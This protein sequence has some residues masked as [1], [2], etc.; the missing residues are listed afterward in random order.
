[1]PSDQTVPPM[2]ND[3]KERSVE[4]GVVAQRLRA[5]AVLTEDPGL[6]LRPTLQLTTMCES[7]LFWTRKALHTHDA[8]TCV[9]QTHV[10]IK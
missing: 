9:G 2:S 5:Q 8:E 4:T 3:P 6:V 1:M 7:G 10:H